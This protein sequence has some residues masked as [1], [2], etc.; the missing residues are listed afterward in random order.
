MKAY[1]GVA[2]QIHV[3]LTSALVG[4]QWSSSRPC[5]FTARERGPRYPLDR[6]L[7]GPQGWSG[8]YGEVK[9]LNL[10]GLKGAKGSI[11]VKALC[12]KPEGRGFD[13]R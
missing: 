4:G 10:L 11:V 9:F 3:L 5:L 1:G 7:S 8:Q 6:R 2:V 13:T 12:Y